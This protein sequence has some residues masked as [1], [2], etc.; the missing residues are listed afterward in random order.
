MLDQK[1]E[2]KA[3]ASVAA[4]TSTI[5]L[6]MTDLAVPT[7]ETAYLCMKMA[8]PADVK[9]HAI[10][11][12]PI[13]T[14]G[15]VHH[16]LLFSC[17]Q[18][19]EDTGTVFECTG[20]PTECSAFYM[21]WAPGLTHVDAPAEAGYAF[22]KGSVTHMALQIHYTNPEGISGVKDSSGF[23]LHYTSNLRK[24]DIGVLTLGVIGYTIPPQQPSFAL[25]PSI[26]PCESQLLLH[27]PICLPTA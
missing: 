22:G 15:F 18:P 14:S 16:M 1:L 8:L 10:R 2:V 24:H 5:S 6:N 20:M 11:Y 17:L 25:P 26:C 23:K 13:V 9:Y 19:Q 4:D 27:I 3:A 7:N 12:E 21:V